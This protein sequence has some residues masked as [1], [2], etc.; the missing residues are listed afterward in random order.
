M[1]GRDAP[2]NYL[3]RLSSGKQFLHDYILSVD[4]AQVYVCFKHFLPKASI[5]IIQPSPCLVW[6]SV[7]FPM[8]CPENF[9]FFFYSIC[10][11][12]APFF[13]FFYYSKDNKQFVFAPTLNLKPQTLH[14]RFQAGCVSVTI[15]LQFWINGEDESP[16]CVFTCLLDCLH[17]SLKAPMSG[18]V[19]THWML[20]FFFVCVCVAAQT[21]QT[22]T[23]SGCTA[24]AS[25]HPLRRHRWQQRH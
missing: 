24:A 23:E 2:S 19:I 13:L 5:T 1:H 7:C 3:A 9:F 21:F 4:D 17:I 20:F 6:A 25:E 10:K 22:P 15:A 8:A 11:V 12:N 14:P 16:R 18:C